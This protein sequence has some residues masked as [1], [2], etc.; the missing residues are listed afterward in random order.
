MHPAELQIVCAGRC[1]GQRALC[2]HM[3][4]IIGP[5][6]R[7]PRSAGGLMG[8]CARTNGL[9]AGGSLSEQGAEAAHVDLRVSPSEYSRALVNVMLVQ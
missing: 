7:S 3:A 1:G 8:C 2:M 4:L 9:H 5:Q 6:D